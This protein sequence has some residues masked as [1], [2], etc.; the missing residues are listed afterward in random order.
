MGTDRIEK[1]LFKWDVP[2]PE[3]YVPI[4]PEVTKESS[5]NGRGEPIVAID[6]KKVVIKRDNVLEVSHR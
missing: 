2:M 3:S 6:C 5:K 4:N 1:F